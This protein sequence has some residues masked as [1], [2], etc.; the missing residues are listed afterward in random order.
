MEADRDDK[1]GPVVLLRVHQES[2]PAPVR[3]VV[4]R[5]SAGLVQ[6]HQRGAG[7]VRVALLGVDLAPAPVAALG[8]EE[9]L[10]HSRSLP[11][12]CVGVRQAPEP[13]GPVFGVGGLGS[14]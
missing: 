2:D 1:P 11:G 10:R 8:R 13:E 12:L 3:R 6:R 9:I 14:L 4:R 7:C 5:E